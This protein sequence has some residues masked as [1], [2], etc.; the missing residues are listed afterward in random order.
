MADGSLTRAE[1]HHL[2]RQQRHIRQAER[3]A[4][5]DGVVTQDEKYHV[6]SKVMK[7]DD[8]QLYKVRINKNNN[9]DLIISMEHAEAIED[10][11][12]VIRK[13]KRSEKRMG[14]LPREH[15]TDL[16]DAFDLDTFYYA[17]V[18]M[19]GEQAFRHQHGQEF[20]LR[21]MRRRHEGKRAPDHLF[22]HVHAQPRILPRQVSQR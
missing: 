6:I 5:A 16:S 4:K 10:R 12:G 22:I 13:D 20:Q 3:Q 14:T 8:P 21:F 11:K 7:E 15:A 2:Q 1:A 9:R 18:R 17:K 19:R